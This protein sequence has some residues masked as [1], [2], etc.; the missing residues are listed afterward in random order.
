MGALTGIASLY[1]HTIRLNQANPFIMLKVLVLMLVVATQMHSGLA[2]KCHVCGEAKVQPSNMGPPVY[3]GMCSNEHDLGKT[4]S[5]PQDK[6]TCF[7]STMTYSGHM[8]GAA[9]AANIGMMGPGNQGKEGIVRGCIEPLTPV[10][11]C[12][13][14]NQP[15]VEMRMCLCHSDSCN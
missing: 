10:D 13:S 12:K 7:N 8:K 15:G 3:G 1:S 4:M 14:M 2:R 6:N 5:C 9:A 11:D